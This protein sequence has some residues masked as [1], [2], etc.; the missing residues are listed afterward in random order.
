MTALFRLS[1]IQYGLLATI[2]LGMVVKLLLFDYLYIDYGFY[3]SR[4]I[5]D[6]KANG[7]LSALKEPF[8]NY[9]PTYMYVLVLIAKLDLY[10]LYAIKIVSV[11]FDY[12][13][14]FFVGQLLYLYYKKELV[15]WISFAVVPLI[16]TVL[17]N[18]AFMSQCDSLYVSFIVG[19]V[20]F[21]FT[22]RQFAAVL[23]LGIAFALKVQTALILPFYFIYMLRGHIK[24]YFFLMI[25]LIYVVSIVPVWMV[26]RSLTD[27]LTVYVAQAEYNEELVKNFPNIYLWIG[28]LGDVAKWIGLGSVLLLTL[29][30]GWCLSNREKYTFTLEAW[31]K[32]IFLSAIIC[33]FLLP[34]M[35]ERYMYLGDVFAIV[36]IALNRKNIVA[37]LGII[38]VSFYSY[39]RCIYM[40]SF[41]A[42][43]NYPSR[44][45]AIF[46]SIPWE[47][48]S[49]LYIIIILYVL[50]DLVTT[51]KRSKLKDDEFVFQ[52]IK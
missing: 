34:G 17:L 3:L 14:A 39:V 29:L 11:S 35:L 37:G 9:A 50:Y 36:Y 32:L 42:D 33:P 45:F 12:V 25:P 48:V 26:G 41:S 21:L 20:Y 18:S 2:I 52:E 43:G 1:K 51:L 47:A 22:K 8:Y 30:G 6:I 15:L 28:S 16:P 23:F 44:P 38:F 49:I 10:P 40:F 24:W 19:S 46:E 5:G 27:L 13:L 4:W 7:Y 31:Y